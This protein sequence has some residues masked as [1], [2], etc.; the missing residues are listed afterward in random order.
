MFYIPAIPEPREELTGG[1]TNIDSDHKLIHDG[2]GFFV[3]KKSTKYLSRVS[4]ED[5]VTANIL[6][7][8]PFIETDLLD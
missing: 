2:Y 4:N 7:K 3:L 8:L 5:G 1:F 6:L